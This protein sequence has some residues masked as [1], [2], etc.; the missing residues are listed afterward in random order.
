MFNAT[1]EL[2]HITQAFCFKI[3]ESK[4][5]TTADSQIGFVDK[6]TKLPM[7]HL[8]GRPSLLT[9]LPGSSTTQDAND[10]GEWR[11][12]FRSMVRGYQIVYMLM[13]NSINQQQEGMKQS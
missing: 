13:P 10:F 3:Y 11:G 8:L 9:G 5:I 12:V 6:D 1:K 7:Y 2:Y 4:S